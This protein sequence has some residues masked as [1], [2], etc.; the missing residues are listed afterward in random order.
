MLILRIRKYKLYF[1]NTQQQ[2]VIPK[3]AYKT[4]RLKTKLPN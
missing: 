1:L 2:C 3:F 4:K